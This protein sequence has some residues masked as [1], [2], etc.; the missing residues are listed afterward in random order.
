LSGYNFTHP[1]FNNPVQVNR[2]RD[3]MDF[4][5][6][7]IN[8]QE[9][10]ILIPAGSEWKYLDN[11]SDQGI[12]W[13]A[14][15]FND[16]SW[17]AGPG[18]LG[19]GDNDVVTKVS[20]GPSSSNKYPTTYFRH[21]FVVDSLDSITSLRLRVLRDD[22]V[23]VYLNGNEVWRDNMPSSKITYRTLASASVSGVNETVYYETYLAS[24]F[25]KQGT[26]LIASEVH[27]S[28]AG[29]SDLGFDLQL[30]ALIFKR[31]IPPQLVWNPVP[32]KIEL[33]WNTT[34]NRWRLFSALHLNTSNSSWSPVTQGI[35]VSNGM[36]R[37]SIY[38]TQDVQ[39]FLLQK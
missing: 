24:S 27:Q 21:Q 32:G 19:Y 8:D 30:T 22:G 7:S 6:L 31:A 4:Q 37:L 33:Q 13:A 2:H 23:V 26:N 38:P 15:N 36:Y 3:G 29:S 14:L 5:G 11:G 34:D 16:S 17:K 28:S 1:N 9:L 12:N 10:V 39:F 35:A 18:E 20:Y 25:L